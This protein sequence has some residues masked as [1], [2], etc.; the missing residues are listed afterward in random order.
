M[1]VRSAQGLLVVAA[2]SLAGCG[3]MQGWFGAQ[4]QAANEQHAPASGQN[5]Q[6]VPVPA[7]QFTDIP[8]PS[9]S[10]LELARTLVL[11]GR[12]DWTGRAYFETQIGRAHV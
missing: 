7:T 12:E 11:C 3:S 1:L 2:L 10:R 4:P 8:V 5:S 6:S 9:N